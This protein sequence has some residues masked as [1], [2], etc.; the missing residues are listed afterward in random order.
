MRSLN[1]ILLIAACVGAA[2]TVPGCAVA[3][4]EPDRRAFRRLAD[5]STGWFKSRVPGLGRQMAGS[6]GYV[7]FPESVQWGMLFTGGAYGRGAV[8]EP[9][10][11]QIGWAS[12]N[13]GSL[14]VQLGMQT[15]RLLVVFENQDVLRRFKGN[16]LFGTANSIAIADE[17]GR[18]LRTAFDDGVA[19]YEG[20][21]QGLMLGANLAMNLM[22]Y[23]PLSAAEHAAEQA[24]A[25]PEPESPS[26]PRRTTASAAKAHGV[27]SR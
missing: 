2:G 26:P 11:D 15:F 5:D 17:S 18:C 27:V 12:I 24:D 7:V 1:F 25:P 16:Q 8:Y 19:L 13:S 23:E 4:A 10:G 14:G 21:N 22:R 3:P 20:A 6:A 9:G